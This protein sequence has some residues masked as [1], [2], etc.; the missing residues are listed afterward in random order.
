MGLNPGKVIVLVGIQ[1]MVS[2]MDLIKF[3][4]SKSSVLRIVT[5]FC[6]FNIVCMLASFAGHT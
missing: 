2:E 6:S 4:F 1:E 5:L 3:L